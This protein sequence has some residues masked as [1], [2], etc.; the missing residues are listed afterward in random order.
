MNMGT[1]YII[2][3]DRFFRNAR[4]FDPSRW[5]REES[6]E[7]VVDPY[8]FLPFGFGARMCIGRRTAEQEIYLTT[9]KVFQ[10]F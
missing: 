6:G 5:D 3:S 2:Q 8:A 9:V 1:A 10:I 7:D 4:E